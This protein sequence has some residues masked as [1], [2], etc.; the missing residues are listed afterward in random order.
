MKSK[1]AFLG[2]IKERFTGK[3]LVIYIILLVFLIF[4]FSKFGAPGMIEFLKQASLEY[5]FIAGFLFALALIIKS[6][7]FHL[8]LL[9][10]KNV[11][12]KNSLIIQVIAQ[13][14][15][16]YSVG[17]FESTK[18]A[19]L[20]KI[21]K[22]PE[23]KS[24]EILVLEKTFDLFINAVILILALPYLESFFPSLAGKMLG[25]SIVL[26]IGISIAGAYLFETKYKEIKI[27]YA[28]LVLG[29]TFA[30]ALINLGA[31]YFTFISLGINLTIQLLF[32]VYAILSIV[33]SISIVPFGLGIKEPLIVFFAEVTV[34][35]PESTALALLL[36]LI[37]FASYGILAVAMFAV[38]KL[39]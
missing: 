36:N 30:Y 29:V 7:R 9:K 19:P 17:I 37:M 33:I 23:K 2:T 38:Y 18:I 14:I 24:V 8:M 4:F 20:K 13:T 28:L 26:L 15:S 27:N 11:N 34:G 25:I 16:M 39:K 10:V 1:G 6:I 3:L 22:I 32:V 35:V 12:W 5:V 21:E 31:L